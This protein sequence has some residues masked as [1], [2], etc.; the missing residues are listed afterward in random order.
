MLM[1]IASIS[2]RFQGH[3]CQIAELLP[4]I[5]QIFLLQQLA[6]QHIPQ[7][8]VTRKQLQR[9]PGYYFYYMLD[10]QFPVLFLTRLI[11]I[12]Q[13]LCQLNNLLFYWVI[14]LYLWCRFVS[15]LVFLFLSA[16]ILVLCLHT[17]LTI[18]IPINSVCSIE[19]GL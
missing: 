16:I 4:T 15:V 17:L 3:G 2:I 1:H 13:H 18:G 8:Q 5:E 19:L 10:Q 9:V 7:V 14:R 6:F 11:Q 12:Y